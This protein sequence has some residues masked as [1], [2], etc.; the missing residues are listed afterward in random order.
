MRVRREVPAIP[1]EVKGPG[2]PSHL[3]HPC[4]MDQVGSAGSVSKS[5]SILF[6]LVWLTCPSIQTSRVKVNAGQ[7]GGHRGRLERTS[8]NPGQTSCCTF[9][10]YWPGQ[11]SRG[12]EDRIRAWTMAK[13]D[14]LADQI[15]LRQTT[16]PRAWEGQNIAWPVCGP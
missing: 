15:A 16:V 11:G 6:D 14:C 9:L 3:F 2:Q 10:L 4:W 12:D 8:V 5:V 7:S 1:R 13:I